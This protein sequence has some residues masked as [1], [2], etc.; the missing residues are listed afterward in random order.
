VIDSS[1]RPIRR[2]LLKRLRLRGQKPLNDADESF[3]RA[4]AKRMA[5]LDVTG[6]EPATPIE[7]RGEAFYVLLGS[8]VRLEIRD[9]GGYPT[10]V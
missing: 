8:N 7:D 2:P 5:R 3:S 10:E 6:V 1:Y 4:V 9:D